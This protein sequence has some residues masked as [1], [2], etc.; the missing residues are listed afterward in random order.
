MMAALEQVPPSPFQF[1]AQLRAGRAQTSDAADTVLSVFAHPFLQ[2]AR[3]LLAAV[4]VTE[5]ALT[6]A[7]H[8]VHVSPA[9]HVAPPA[10][11]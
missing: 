1:V 6:T 10:Q 11:K 5:A 7:V 9:L 4:H 8:A 2:V 3:L